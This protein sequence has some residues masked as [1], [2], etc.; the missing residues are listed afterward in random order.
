MSDPAP[1]YEPSVAFMP[2]NRWSTLFPIRQDTLKKLGEEAAKTAATVSMHDMIPPG[3]AV[4]DDVPLSFN[5]SDQYID[6]IP[7]QPPMSL[8]RVLATLKEVSDAAE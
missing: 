8:V 7:N 5:I 4:D 3:W 1:L 2:D 6:W